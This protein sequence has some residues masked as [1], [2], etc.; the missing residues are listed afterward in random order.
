MTLDAGTKLGPYEV[1]TPLGAGGMG[2]VYRAHDPRLGR[3]V[4]IKVLPATFSQDADRLKRF[5]SEARAAGVLNHPGI[6]AVYDFGTNPDGA[7]YIVTE[8]L[9]GETLRS[10]LS[11]GPVPIRKALDWA[12]QIARGLAAAHEKGIVHRDLKPENLFLTRDGRVKILDFGLAKLKVENEPGTQTDLRTISGT[13]PGVVLGTMGYMSPEQVRGKAADRRTDIFAFGAILYEM[14]SGQRAFRGDTAA[15]TITAILTKEPTDLSTTN[16]EIHPGL[17]RI[18]RHCLEKNPEERFE[19]ARDVAFDL[20]ALSTVSTPTGVLPA[21]VAAQ[22]VA[23]KRRGWVLPAIAAAAIALAAGA[24]AGFRLGKKAGFVPP[25]SYQQLTFRRGELYASRFAPDGQTVIYAA[26]WDGKPVEIFA[27]RTDRPE[28][29]VFGLAG[30]EVASISKAGEMLVLLDRHVEEPFIRAGTLA[31]VSV[32]GGVAPRSIMDG[33]EWA[34]WA[35]DGS[36]YALIRDI[37]SRK[38]LEYPA[39]KVLYQTTGWISHPRVSPKGDLVAFIDHPIRRDDGGSVMV[40]DRDGKRRTLAG[41]FSSLQGL[42]WAPTEEV[43]FTGTRSGGN[44]AIHAVSLTGRERLLARV[45]ESLT[46]QDI[47]SDGRTLVS[48]D[49]IRIGVLGKAAGETTERDLSWL[50]WSAAFDLSHDGR[51]LLF[52]ESGEGSGPAYSCFIRGTDGSPPVRLGDGTATSLSP[53]GHWVAANTPRADPPQLWIYPTGAGEKRLLAT[54]KLNVESSADWLPDGKTIAFTA[55]EPGHG[56]RVFVIGATN[57]TPKAVTPEG[58]RL[59][60][61]CPT[62][63]GKAV[64]VIGQDRRRYLYHLDGGEP[65]PINGLADD[66]TPTAWSA[67]GRYLYVYRRRDVPVKVSKLDVTTG[68]RELWKELA[69]RDGA[70]IQDVAPVIPT[71]DGAAYVYGYSRTLSDMYVAEGLK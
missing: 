30:A 66:E 56:T 12:V 9:E 45:T 65:Q 13:E 4:A 20:E 44:R 62:P 8:L 71:P 43:W 19:S 48:H 16:K 28:S 7:P 68:K 54:G 23:G 70:G 47:A 3:E 46:I 69:P 58:Y 31:Q 11:A 6:T 37:N 67:D 22:A 59:V 63:D 25:P 14:L 60:P 29:R 10:R 17:D 55:A 21:S 57:G 49:V 53:D 34:D 42:A 18:V 26:A 36:S 61:R 51:T 1:V 5:E 24:A 64:I 41:V 2:E 33:V 38:Q 27:T 50:D 40:V 15:D 35:P 52:N 32:S 39:G